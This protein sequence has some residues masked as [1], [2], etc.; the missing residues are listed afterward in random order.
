MDERWAVAEQVAQPFCCCIAPY[1]IKL[2]DM[3]TPAKNFEGNVI[4]F[5]RGQQCGQYILV[6]LHV[7]GS[8]QHILLF[9]LPLLVFI[10]L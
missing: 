4:E 8:L 6:T 3:F 7:S 9:S 5:S 10:G 1:A 2:N